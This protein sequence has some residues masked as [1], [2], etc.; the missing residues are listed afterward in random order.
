MIQDIGSEQL[1][2]NRRKELF[3]ALVDAQDHEMSVAQSRTLMAQRFG[4]DESQVRLIEREGMELE[5]P[6]LG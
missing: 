3:L 1:S 2:E 5:W 4:V 6:P